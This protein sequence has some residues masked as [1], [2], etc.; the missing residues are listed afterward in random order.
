M[1]FDASEYS[2]HERAAKGQATT[3]PI[4][5]G[6]GIAEAPGDCDVPSGSP[7]KRHKERDQGRDYKREDKRGKS[8]MDGSME[9]RADSRADSRTDNRLLWSGVY[10]VLFVGEPSAREEALRLFQPSFASAEGSDFG[11]IEG[12]YTLREVDVVILGW[13]RDSLKET[14]K[15]AY[16][17][18][19][20]PKE[21][22]EVS[23]LSGTTLR[24]AM[25]E[26]NASYPNA[27]V[28]V[29]LNEE[30]RDALDSLRMQG[31]R[32]GA[33][34][35]FSKSTFLGRG[36]GL[37]GVIKGFFQ[38][39]LQ[40]RR[41]LLRVLRNGME[42]QKT[43]REMRRAFEELGRRVAERT[44]ELSEANASLQA[45]VTERVRAEAALVESLERYRLLSDCMAQLVWTTNLKGECIYCN[46]HWV[47]YTG[48]SL[49]QAPYPSWVDFIHPEDRAET[50]ALWEQSLKTGGAFEHEYRV[51]NHSVDYRW[52]LSR[53]V[54]RRNTE[55]E[56]VE[57]IATATDIDD[58]K[59]V[60]QRLMDAH[61]E[62]GIRILERT[63]QLAHA[64]ELLHAEV[65]ERKRLESEAQRARE[66]AEAANRAKSEFLANMSHEI[67]TPMNGILGMTE[68]LLD[69]KV[70]PQQSEYLR[71]AKKSG[72]S[73][74]SLI[75]NVL[76]FAKIEAG[77]LQLERD[78]FNLR[79]LLGDIVKTLGVR[80]I[81]KKLEMVLDIRP[82]VP[83]VVM[84]DSGRLRQV[85]VNLV[86]NA[87]KFTDVGEVATSVQVASAQGN[88]MGLRF[89]V[90]D[91]GIGISRDK[92]EVIFDAFSQADGSMT[93]R[94][95]GTGL[96]LAIASSLV[97]EM[98]GR[99]E[100]YSGAGK[101]SAFEFTLPME[102]VAMPEPVSHTESGVSSPT[103]VEEGLAGLKVLVLESH[104]STSRVEVE[105]LRN[106]GMTPVA[107][108]RWDEAV[109]ALRL[110]RE[111]STPYRLIIAD[112]ALP[113][114]AET[115]DPTGT[116][117]DFIL[118]EPEPRPAV[119]LTLPP[120]AASAEAERAWA[121]PAGW[122]VSRPVTSSQLLE[123]CAFSMGLRTPPSGRARAAAKPADKALGR[124][125]LIAE[126][127]PVN[128][129][130]AETMLLGSGHFVVIANNGLEALQAL[131][132]E[133]F[134][135]VLMDV[136][137]PEMDG[138]EATRRIR[139]MEQPWK[140]I[141]I[142]AMTAHAM[143]GDR[144][145]CLEAGMDYYLSKPFRKQQLLEVVE[146]FGGKMK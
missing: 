144:E 97:R 121:G 12:S 11:V 116:F 66:Q 133:A 103:S 109:E 100:V 10:R 35:V 5:G 43:L 96:G 128:Q 40:E 19:N 137:M 63:S 78:Q 139:S 38:Q 82:D 83:S 88:W 126:D 111:E 76:D 8:S 135:L 98:G 95:G 112:A 106:A 134:D 101:G 85:I 18:A 74:L 94:F 117:A 118:K 65:A 123:A 107:V 89:E 80:A 36:S 104:A 73:L 28:F 4:E 62:L 115:K 71:L 26:I 75:N 120:A 50:L 6:G 70:N 136:Q 138:L 105:M 102:V 33:Q 113:H 81:Q 41:G 55:G 17:E 87:I 27:A 140:T 16:K 23:P 57:W 21:L 25:Q 44:L 14:L 86:G 42:R 46:Q 145:R 47:A 125:V 143:N 130:V 22:K 7:P 53:A 64:N 92:H 24:G 90:K 141:P 110:A 146:Q 69:T 61:D 60:E 30:N 132:R 124:R 77:K 91:T 129:R 45:E 52:H 56:I 37:L 122:V 20:E 9:G 127:N 68:L 13:T 99:I 119:V 51:R 93:R 54:P 131:E 49:T 59:R 72:E 32:L 31:L 15:E 58:Q 79:D 3:P 48:Q 1:N 67:R 2:P 84:G 34:E 39:S 108:A 142:I 114:S 29:Y